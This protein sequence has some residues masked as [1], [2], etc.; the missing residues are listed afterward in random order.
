MTPYGFYGFLLLF[1]YAHCICIHFCSIQ[2]TMMPSRKNRPQRLPIY[3]SFF[4]GLL[5]IEQHDLYAFIAKH[6]NQIEWPKCYP[7]KLLSRIS[8]VFDMHSI[9]R[10]WILNKI[11]ILIQKYF[12]GDH[13][14]PFYSISLSPLCDSLFSAL[15]HI[16]FHRHFIK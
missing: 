15:H 11:S 14:A 7:K 2:A 5:Y 9:S 3:D 8:L 10:R 4:A 1:S 6:L 12:N 16:S 13:C